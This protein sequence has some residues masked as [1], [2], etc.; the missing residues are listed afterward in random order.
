MDEVAQP[1]FVGESVVTRHG[2]P[3]DGTDA[4]KGAFSSPGH[5]A[6]WAVTLVV[7][8]A[9]LGG[10]S[11]LMIDRLQ[12]G[13]LLSAGDAEA[14]R[15]ITDVWPTGASGEY[16][17]TVGELIETLD[18]E[19]VEMAQLAAE[20]AVEADPG[21]AFAWARIAYYRAEETGAVDEETIAALLQSMRRCGLCDPELVRW[22][23]NFVLSNWD[24]M[25]E[26]VRRAAFMHADV[27]RWTG[28]NAEFLAEMRV[29]AN[30]ANIPYDEYR[31]AVNT[32]VRSW[33]IEP[34]DDE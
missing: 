2:R 14:R 23:F 7:G 1:E 20:R 10:V 18:P 21:R 15:T 5:V 11:I 17:E 30:A 25:P 31:S 22:R 9:A 34:L 32:P 27:L 8:L 26:Q 16:Y 4:P 13:L 19:N 33:D 6:L 3:D 12:T 24:Q 28:A 29:K